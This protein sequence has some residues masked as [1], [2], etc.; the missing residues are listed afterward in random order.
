MGFLDTLFGNDSADAA[1]KAAAD[2]FAKQQAASGELKNFGSQYAGRF[3]DLA[4]SFSPW[5]ETGGGANDALRN[6]LADPSSIRSLPAYA[7]GVAEGT[8]AID[9]SALANGNL[10]SGKTGKALVRFGENNFDKTYG[11]QVARLLGVS[12][13]GLD[14]TGRGVATEGTGLQG[15]LGA[16]TSAYGGDMTSAGTIGQGDI[17]AANAK[18]SG[19]QNLLNLGGSVLGMG[20]SGGGLGRVSSFATSGMNKL[21]GGG[22]PSG[23]GA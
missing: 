14:A 19:L 5:S 16:R 15:E 3:G 13:Q 2:T 7:T 1:K 22:S 9:H 21:F 23:Y 18:T 12:Q 10:F 6:L 20:L 8:R 17:A 4:K 11:D